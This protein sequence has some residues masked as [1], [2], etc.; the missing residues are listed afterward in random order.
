MFDLARALIGKGCR[1]SIFTNYPQW[2]ATRFGLPRDQVISFARHGYLQ[3]LVGMALGENFLQHLESRLHRS[4]G[5][6][7]CQALKKHQPQGGWDAVLCMS[8]V[9]EESFEWFRTTKTV[10]VLHRGSTHIRHQWKLLREEED[11][12]GLPI[13]KP[14]DWIISREEREYQLADA[15]RVQSP[16]ALQGFQQ[17]NSSQSQV[18]LIPLGVNLRSFAAN[19]EQ[20][21]ER[22][23]RIRSGQ[24]LRVLGVGTFCLRKGAFD[25]PKLI[26]QI[27]NN[28]FEFRFVGKIGSDGA[29]LARQLD[30]KAEFRSKVPQDHLPSEYAWGDLFLL[31]SIED[32]FAVVVT[33]AMACGLPVIVSTNTGANFFVKEG[34]NG[35]VVPIRAP[36]VIAKLLESLEKDREKLAKVVENCQ[37]VIKPW[38]WNDVAEETLKDLNEQVSKKRSQRKHLFSSDPS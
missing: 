35:W 21:K 23:Q 7:A 15:I 16:F 32:G 19:P 22:L 37:E 3:K 13:S 31:P 34:I 12:A 25:I 38:D 29:K 30:S 17:F 5:K 8:G 9:A 1:V 4:F 18:A 27:P 20:K 33:Q 6:W 14:T 11:R 36:E 28:R 26:E 10:C 2:A 24:P